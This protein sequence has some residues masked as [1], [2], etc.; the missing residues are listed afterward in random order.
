[1]TIRETQKKANKLQCL[2]FHYSHNIEIINGALI[3][4]NFQKDKFAFYSEVEK[5]HFI[6][7]TNGH[8][9]HDYK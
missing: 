3:Q 5:T 2:R 1:M 8:K 7:Y 4:C 9:K 6:T